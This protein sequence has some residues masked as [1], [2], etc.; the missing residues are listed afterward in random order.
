MPT[1]YTG[2]IKFVLMYSRGHSCR[3][4][5]HMRNKINLQTK[6]MP[7]KNAVQPNPKKN[8]KKNK[9]RNKPS[10]K[11]ITLDKRLT[12]A[13]REYLKCALASPDFSVSSF[14]GIPDTYSGRVVT[15]R[16]ETTVPLAGLGTAGQ[17]LYIYSS[18]V[19]GIAYFYS[20]RAAGTIVPMTLVPVRY[21]DTVSLMPGLYADANFSAF[22]FASSQI[23]IVPLV[24]QFNWTGS[25]QLFRG[26]L[27]TADVNVAVTGTTGGT[28]IRKQLIGDDF[29]NGVKPEAVCP[30]IEG[31]YSVARNTD[32]HYS[33]QPIDPS[34]Y[35]SD[36]YET[37]VAGPGQGT[38]LTTSGQ[39][40]PMPGWGT[41]E[42][43]C[44]K[45]PAFSTT[46]NIGVLRAWACLEFQVPS[47]SV[48]YDYSH[49]SPAHDPLALELLL[50]FTKV[51]PPCVSYK[52]NANFWQSFLN[53]LDRVG[54]AITTAAGG[55]RQI[56]DAA[57]SIV[58]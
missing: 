7:A 35:F 33:F 38:F 50:A 29:V 26:Y 40:V 10:I 1:D 46:G 41:M 14:S 6:V 28:C 45:I 36:L 49:M 13:G 51:M 20:T 12:A 25:I 43:I 19:P 15:K 48:L 22:R 16:Y 9:R 17:D 34:M 4:P 39:N 3:D 58:F 37:T 32:S 31:A 5:I 56:S 30:F 27:R 53:W 24:N 2:K 44:Y 55:V 57:A 23:E 52:D 54:P 47:T 8:N 42:T 18:N 11:S 21:P